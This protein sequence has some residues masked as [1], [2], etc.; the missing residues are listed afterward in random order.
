[1]RKNQS[2]RGFTLIELLV[3][4]A[5]IGILSS[6]VLASLNTARNKAKD[7]SAISSISQI[8]TSAE[9]IYANSSNQYATSG[10]GSSANFCPTWDANNRATG[11]GT[12]NSV[13]VF[14]LIKA[15][16]VALAGSSGALTNNTYT[17]YY[18]CKA[19][20][21]SYAVNI[22]LSSTGYY[23][24][25]SSGFAGNRA[26]AGVVGDDTAGYSCPTN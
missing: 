2:E 24:V 25:D 1:M 11:Q 3:V 8:R 16:Q 7:A 21:G 13:D 18:D 10:S 19:T 26:T 12:A 22:K 17:G 23:C 4:I 5:I 9:L 15:A 6:V 14:N 20:S